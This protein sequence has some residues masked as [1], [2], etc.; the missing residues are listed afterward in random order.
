LESYKVRVFLR[1]GENVS[2]H[3]YSKHTFR[4]KKGNQG[5]YIKQLEARGPIVEEWP[6]RSYQKLFEGLPIR[7]EKRETLKVSSIES[8]IEKIGGSISVSSFQNGME[9]EKMLDGSNRTFWHTR[10]K[11]TLAKPPHFVILENPYGR[12]IDGLSYATWSGGNGNG[13][14][15]AYSV[16]PIPVLRKTIRVRVHHLWPT[17]P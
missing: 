15:Q 7:A 16:N 2:V 10:F 4:K 8:N 13:Q 9:K 17:P 12:V 11:P 5:I 3:C 6:P 14:V 1:P